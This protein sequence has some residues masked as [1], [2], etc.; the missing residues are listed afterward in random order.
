MPAMRDFR[1]DPQFQAL[2]AR[3]H[4]IDYWKACGAPDGCDV[5]DGK[6]TCH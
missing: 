5:T 6:V 4:L 3:L 2:A 1:K